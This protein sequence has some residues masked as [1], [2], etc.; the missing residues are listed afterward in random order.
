MRQ[1]LA[2]A[3]LPVAVARHYHEE[4]VTLIVL[5]EYPEEKTAVMMVK[6]DPAEPR[7]NYAAGV[8]RWQ[9]TADTWEYTG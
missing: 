2:Y 9:R 6:I 5:T 8:H 7:P 1:T 3:D 4:D